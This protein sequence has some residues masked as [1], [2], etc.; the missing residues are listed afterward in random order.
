VVFLPFE[1]ICGCSLQSR[2]ID[3]TVHVVRR[4]RV[5]IEHHVEDVLTEYV[6]ALPITSAQFACECSLAM[7]CDVVT[8]NLHTNAWSIK[9]DRVPRR[10]REERVKNKHGLTTAHLAVCLEVGLVCRVGS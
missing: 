4:V 6:Y 8:R 2:L 1:T 7:G 5:H 10:L 3:G 9:L